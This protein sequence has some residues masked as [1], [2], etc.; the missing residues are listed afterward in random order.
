MGAYEG[1]TAPLEFGVN[2][3]LTISRVT[4]T[5]TSPAAKR[6]DANGDGIVN[7]LDYDIW[8]SHYNP[9]LIQSGGSTIGDFN[10][11][12]KVDGVDFVIWLNN[13]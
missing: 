2:A 4:P 10:N 9:T 1:G 7:E 6:G 13:I 11:D 5:V 8:K 12:T 3:Y